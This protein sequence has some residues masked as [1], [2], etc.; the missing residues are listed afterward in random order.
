MSRIR[1]FARHIYGQVFISALRGLHSRVQP[2]DA[3]ALRAR[4]GAVTLHV[5]AP[6]A[7]VLRESA[8]AA[9]VEDDV[10]GVNYFALCQTSPLWRRARMYVIEPHA[11]YADYA[12]AVSL[13][14]EI[15][16]TVDVIVKGALSLSKV[17]SASHLVRALAKVEGVR[18]NLAN[19]MYLSDF[20]HSSFAR[21]IAEYPDRTFCGSKSLLWTISFGVAAGYRNI[22]LHGFDFS[23]DYAYAAEDDE[24]ARPRPNTWVA[25][26]ET[27][28]Y[29]VDQVAEL[30]ATLPGR[31]V[32]LFQSRCDGPLSTMLPAYEARALSQEP[33]L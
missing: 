17:G 22:V 23:Q 10:L 27:T 32:R 19:D 3:V 4:S 1:K 11:T 5:V 25:D 15:N 14:T 31:G 6:G 8:A 24:Q 28:R 12:R 2:L 13:V 20:D 18:V 16:G 7:S 30:A 33:P 29:V 9:L 26:D 21:A